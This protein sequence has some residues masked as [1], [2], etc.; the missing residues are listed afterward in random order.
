MK[1][2]IGTIRINAIP[3]SRRAYNEFRGWWE[4]PAD[5]NGDDEGYLVEYVDG[6]KPNTDQYGGYVT[7]L[8]KEQFDITYREA[9]GLTFGEALEG[10][11]LGKKAA[12]VGWNGKGMFVFLVDGS[13]FAVNRK[14]LLGIYPEGHIVEYR[15]HI[16]M[17]TVDDQIVPWVASQSDVLAED[18]ALVA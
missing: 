13:T 9:S 17:K 14:P 3:M 6:G 12:R 10:L 11:K 1:Q 2:F 5:E 15:S 4:L 16:D 8:L 18:W 7:W